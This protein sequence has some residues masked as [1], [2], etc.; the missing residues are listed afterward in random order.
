MVNMHEEAVPHPEILLDYRP[1]SNGNAF[2]AGADNLILFGKFDPS[3][4]EELFD[5]AEDRIT[6]MLVHELEHWAQSLFFTTDEHREVM[7][8]FIDV[9]YERN[10]P[11]LEK[12]LAFPSPFWLMQYTHE[13]S[14]IPYREVKL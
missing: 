11:M 10:C 7:N 1:M 6:F 9:C 3:N 13:T 4:A 14:H 8:A 2:Y 5:S 12:A